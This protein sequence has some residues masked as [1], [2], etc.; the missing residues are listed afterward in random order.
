MTGDATHR[1][2]EM[3]MRSLCLA[4]ATVLLLGAAPAAASIRIVDS[5]YRN[6]VLLITG[7]TRPHKRVTLDG[8]YVTQ[9][10]A[11]GHF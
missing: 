1:C 4:L 3:T 8:K 10:D 11:G 6:G 2:G 9:S 7:Q 5:I